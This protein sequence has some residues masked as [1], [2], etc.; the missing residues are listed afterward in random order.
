MPEQHLED[1]P[2]ASEGAIH[3]KSEAV[4]VFVRL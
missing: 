4:L 3:M 2:H 1:G